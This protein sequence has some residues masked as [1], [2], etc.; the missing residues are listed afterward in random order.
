MKRCLQCG[1]ILNNNQK[2]NKFCSS[3]CAATYNNKN[4]NI[5]HCGPV[6]LIYRVSADDFIKF[7]NASETLSELCKNQVINYL[8]PILEN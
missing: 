8:V 5:D 6:Q 4:R 7:L 3:S 1:A 2:R